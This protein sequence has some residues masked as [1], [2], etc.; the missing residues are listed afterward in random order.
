MADFIPFNQLRLA[1]NELAYVAE[2]AQN[3]LQERFTARCAARLEDLLA[4]A[5]V[6]LTPSGTSAL[7]P[8]RDDS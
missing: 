5:R 4:G 3:L 8:M 7:A 1:G 2:A 6:F